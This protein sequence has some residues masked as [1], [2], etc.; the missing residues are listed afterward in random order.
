VR[1]RVFFS[2]KTQKSEQLIVINANKYP[3]LL[4]GTRNLSPIE[5][6]LKVIGKRFDKFVLE[7]HM[8]DGDG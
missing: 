2:Q 3:Y 8:R 1:I 7:L 4:M 6:E 5:L